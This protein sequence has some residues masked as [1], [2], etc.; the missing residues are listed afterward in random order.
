MGEVENVYP[1][2]VRPDGNPKARAVIDAFFVAGPAMWRG[3]GI[4]E[5][6][7]L[8]LKEGDLSR[9]LDQDK[10]LPEA[11]R[12]GDVIVGRINPDQCPM[13]GNGCDPANP[14]G[15]CMVSAEGSCGIWYRNRKA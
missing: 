9:G 2:A 5:D 10:E 13:F 15:P 4:I 14:Y 1:G 6:S 12:C 3:L 8:Y 11:C 7:G